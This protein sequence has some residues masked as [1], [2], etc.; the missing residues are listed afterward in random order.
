M[1]AARE[2]I[3]GVAIGAVMAALFILAVK[4]ITKVLV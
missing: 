3:K 2:I 1:S 4:L